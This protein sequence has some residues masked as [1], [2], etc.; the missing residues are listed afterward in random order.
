[1]TRE[2]FKQRWD[3]PDCDITFDEV[4]DCAKEWGLFE[5][6]RINPIN[7]VRYKVLVAAGCSD[8]EEY[9]PIY[10]FDESRV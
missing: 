1:M 4:A 5:R 3:S 9:N 7:T 8:A 10:I 6:P 2:E